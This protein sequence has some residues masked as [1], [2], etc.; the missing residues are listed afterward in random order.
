MKHRWI[1]MMAAAVLLLAACGG[2]DAVVTTA[3]AGGAATTAAGTATTQALEGATAAA[4]QVAIDEMVAGGFAREDAECYVNSILSEFGL[5][6]LAAMSEGSE[7]PADVTAR[8]MALFAEC[9]IDL[10]GATGGLGEMPLDF[11]ELASP[12]DEVDGP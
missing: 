10:G 4:A 5:E 7:V 6:E 11:R 12:R 1:P 9:G 8:M 2:G 3:A